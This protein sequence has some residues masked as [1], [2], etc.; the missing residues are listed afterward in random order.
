MERNQ[1]ITA[2]PN[3]AF[4]WKRLGVSPRQVRAG[5]AFLEALLYLIPSLALF[6]AFVFIPLARSFEISAFI[7]D[8]IGRLVR[9][10]GLMNYE[11]LFAAPGF[12]NS[13]RQ[14]FLFIAYT[15]P[16]TILISLILALLGNMR[17]KGISFF[18]M[19]FS[20]TIAISGATASLMFLYIYH[21]TVGI[22]YLLSLFGITN[23]RWLVSPNTA[24]LSISITTIW[25]QIGLNTVILLAAMQTIPEELFESAMIDGANAWNKLRHIT[26]PMLSSTFFFLMVVDMLAAF[27]TFTP[28]HIMT[29][30]G[31][32]ETTNLLV[33]S[34]YREFYFNGRYGFAAAQSI[35]L[36]FI[37]LLFTVLQFVFVEKRVF[38]E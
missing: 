2:H 9:F 36:F 14:T 10:I 24:L 25:L 8:P 13:L 29:R 16:P 26:L 27:Q 17:L 3:G 38:Y 20:I 34:I 32:L 33:Y 7:T 18:R 15:V 35:V 28:V 19:V 22:N 6:A 31:P 30:G 11:R 4:P 21:P 37:M 12:L 5:K 1:P 23:I